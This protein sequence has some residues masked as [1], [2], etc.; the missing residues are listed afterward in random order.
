M[1]RTKT[2]GYFIFKVCLFNTSINIFSMLSAEE[3][4][5]ENILKWSVYNQH[6]SSRV[7]TEKKWNYFQVTTGIIASFGGIAEVLGTQQE[8]PQRCFI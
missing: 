6:E 2:F 8:L 5:R 7:S 1:L 3:S 4:R